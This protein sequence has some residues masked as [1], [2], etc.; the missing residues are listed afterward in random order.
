MLAAGRSRAY[1]SLLAKPAP[2]SV[3]MVLD[4]R[5]MTNSI[6]IDLVLEAPGASPGVE[7]S[8]GLERE[9]LGVDNVREQLDG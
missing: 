3:E 5:K 4:A 9:G 2:H 8:D 1:D 6:A 7:L